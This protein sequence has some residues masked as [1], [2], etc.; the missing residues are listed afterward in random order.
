MVMSR[1]TVFA[2]TATFDLLLAMSLLAEGVCFLLRLLTGNRF[3]GRLLTHLVCLFHRLLRHLVLV[4]TWTNHVCL[5][6]LPL[7]QQL[8]PLLLCLLLLLASSC[9]SS[10]RPS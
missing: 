3:L 7:R 9:S 10:S 4:S 1:F 2:A 5:C 8:L 6:L